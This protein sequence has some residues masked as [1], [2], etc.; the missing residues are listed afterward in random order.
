M[1]EIVLYVFHDVVPRLAESV[2]T[3]LQ[4]A[5]QCFYFVVYR[6]KAAAL[7]T[8]YKFK[9]YVHNQGSENGLTPAVHVPKS[10]F[11]NMTREIC[12]LD[13]IRLVHLNISFQNANMMN[14]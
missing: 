6:Y 1:G 11:K 13:V 5:I 2:V 3:L 10:I 8:V 9:L 4:L 12:R 14:C 7:G